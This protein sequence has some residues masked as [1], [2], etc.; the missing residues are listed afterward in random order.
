MHAAPAWQVL[1]SGENYRPV[2]AAFDEGAATQ[3]VP[4]DYDG[5]GQ[6]DPAVY[7]P[8]AGQWI[9]HLSGGNYQRFSVPFGGAGQA[10]AP[11]DYDGDGWTELGLYSITDDTWR[12]RELD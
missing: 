4:A 6:A 11:A 1:L 3:A 2:T 5:D 7:Q 10:A 8:A 9:I 12:T